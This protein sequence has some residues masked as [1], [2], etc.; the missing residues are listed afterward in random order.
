MN[1]HE[2]NQL[3]EPLK[4]RPDLEP[5]QEFV[6]KLKRS[7]KESDKP[8]K[9]NRFGNLNWKIIF[10]FCTV[11]IIMTILSASYLT[12][13]LTNSQFGSDQSL[14][15]KNTSKEKK[16]T[17][18]ELLAANPAYQQLFQELVLDTGMQE[19]SKV[20]IYYFEALKNKNPDELQ[21]YYERTLSKEAKDELFSYY[22]GREIT[23]FK[24]QRTI[25][26]R[27]INQFELKIDLQDHAGDFNEIAWEG[28]SIFLIVEDQ[29]N[30]KVEDSFIRN[31]IEGKVIGKRD[32]SILV[33]ETVDSIHGGS[34]LIDFGTKDKKMLEGIEVGQKVLVW[35]SGLM[36]SYPA[37]S[38]ALKIKVIGRGFELTAKEKQAYERFM[39]KKR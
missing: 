39:G 10:S 12:K 3:L 7:F 34:S 33:A 36:E 27:D 9:L 18:D 28:H 21:K 20:V 22:E 8:S 38:S 16:P 25:P 31:M 4:N 6:R 2:I 17:F 15:V 26:H 14:E 19:Q 29:Q 32:N 1:N 23:K 30:V 24:L 35:N 5:D 13:H 37:K 11:M